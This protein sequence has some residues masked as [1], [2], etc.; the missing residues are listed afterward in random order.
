MLYADF[1]SSVAKMC[2]NDGINVAVD[3]AGCV[4]FS[5]FE[6][7]LP[8]ADTFLYDIKALDEELH[9]K[10]TGKSNSLILCNLERLIKTG[11]KITVRVPVI[12]DF[13]E[14]S[15]VERIHMFCE[16][17]GLDAEF[18]PYHEMGEDKKKAL[19]AFK[20]IK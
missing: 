14:G 12:P 20:K 15:E 13:N 18:L 6:K 9:I 8:Y 5:E 4:P 19:I 17:R 11:K 2:H 10:G 3:T 7:V 1:L 16:E